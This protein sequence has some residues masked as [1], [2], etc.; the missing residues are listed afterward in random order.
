[1]YANEDAGTSYPWLPLW[2]IEC[3]SASFM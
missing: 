2:A 3:G 1:M